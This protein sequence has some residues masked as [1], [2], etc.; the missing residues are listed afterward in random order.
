MK[1]KF[2]VAGKIINLFYNENTEEKELPVVVLNTFDEDGQEIWNK[3][4]ELN[5]KE[6]ILATISNIDWNKE[7]S[8]WYMDKL[9][10]TEEDYS[11]KAD[12]YIELLT[13]K[14]VPEIRKHFFRKARKNLLFIR[15]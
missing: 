5:S 2:E 10:K 7:M 11:G 1:E 14:I 3:S 13:S 6:Y 9:F 4:Q 15:K 8:P 12:E